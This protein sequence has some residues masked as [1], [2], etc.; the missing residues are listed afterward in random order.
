[1]LD[2]NNKANILIT[3]VGGFIGSYF[4]DH[5]LKNTNWNFL[6]IDSFRHKGTYSRLNEIKID[7]NRVKIF[8][9]NLN[10]PIDEVLS[11][12]IGKD[13]QAIINLASDSAV[14]RSISNPRQC[15]ENNTNLIINMLE[16]ARTIPKLEYFIQISTDEVF[17]ETHNGWGH[18]EWDTLM[19]SNPYSASK[20]AQDLLTFSY[21]RSY[22]VP[23]IITHTMN[24]FAERQ[25]PEKFIPKIIGQIL[26][27][28]E[29]LIYTDPKGNI[30]SRYYVH[31][32]DHADAVLFLLE[33]IEIGFYAE[34]KPFPKFNIAGNKE[35]NNLEVAQI[36]ANELNLPL[37]YKL[38]HPE[39]ERPG[40]DK[41]YGL[42]GDKLKALGYKSHS[43][44][45]ENRIREVV[46]WTA[47]NLEWVS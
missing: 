25:D 17:G 36:V 19:P 2:R 26:K 31:C 47:N 40:Y 29:L 20:A 5:Y 43:D 38:I 24:N 8:H 35:L 37:K 3:G 44:N 27:G 45:T 46:R 30:G 33:N 28:E 4:L 15:W 1:M 10:S 34:G 21:W 14:G 6:C 32:Q 9:H 16:F 22:K 7:P 18:L 42:A 23:A 12:K 11:N 13:V 41:N 39:Q